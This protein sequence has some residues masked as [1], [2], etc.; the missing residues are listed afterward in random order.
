MSDS[1]TT[2]SRLTGAI[3]WFLAVLIML[4][5]VIYQ[6]R[7]GPTY[8]KRGQIEIAS[9]VENYRLIR[10]EETTRPAR[11]AIPDLGPNG[12]GTVFY[13]R[14][15]T[16]DPFTALEMQREEGEDGAELVAYLPAQPAAGKLEY[17]LEIEGAGGRQRIP[18][19]GEGVG[20]DDNILIRFKDPVPTPLL[21]SHVMFMFFSVLIGMRAGLAAIVA[22]GNMR[23][24][25]WITLTGLTIGGMV[26]G[27]F[28]QKYAFGEYWTGF[29]WGYDL[30]DNKML[31]M[32][33]AWMVACSTVGL[34]PK[35]K[36][37]VGRVVVVAAAVVMTAVYMI[38]HSM[39][40]SELDYSAV[41]SGVD[42]AEAIGTSDQ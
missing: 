24:L 7:T 25:S 5:A 35:K 19:L 10:S 42:P 17:Y 38:P 22:P 11:V 39:R 40:G 16:D 26:L 9:E 31:I 20:G 36:E 14:Y 30:T 37:G 4:A 2:H 18:T 41:D 21:V 6:R 3:L 12:A 32:F 33:L 15:P 34:R 23:K 27:P 29:P 1:T 8:P 28:V 13:K